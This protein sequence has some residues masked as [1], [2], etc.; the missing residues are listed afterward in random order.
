MHE[1]QFTASGP[2]L[3]GSGFPDAAFSTGEQDVG[4]QWGVRVNA[5]RCGVT[6]QT[7]GGGIAGVCGQ[8]RF[9]KFGVLGTAFG[10]RI[11][12]VGASVVNTN[13]LFNVN[14]PPASF[15]LDSLG[16]GSGT[17]VLGKSGSGLGVHGISGSNTGVLGTSDAGVGVHGISG[18]N[19][20]VLGNSA[21]GIGTQGTSDSS[22]GIFGTSRSGFGIHGLSDGGPGGVFE[23]KN[24]AQVRLLPTTMASP[25]GRVGGGGGELLATSDTGASGETVFRLWF[26]TRAGNEASAAWELVAGSRPFPGASVSE[27]AT[28]IDVKRIQMRLNMVFGTDLNGDGEFGPI[29]KEAVVAFQAREQ[30]PQNGVV[31]AVTWERLFALT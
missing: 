9:S 4:F 8:G 1:D 28:G 5:R 29:T 14:V 16:A 18:S 11:G 13:D 25:E 22:T 19:T 6:G 30:L 24:A 23:S 31:N 3:A 20:G 2:A 26:C 17:G 10:E 7:F 12:V 27:S 15:N 21:T